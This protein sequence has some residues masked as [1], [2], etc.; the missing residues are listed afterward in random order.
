MLALSSF[1]ST[2]FGI[3]KLITY[4]MFT[5]WHFERP[6]SLYYQEASYDTSWCKNGI[7]YFCYNNQTAVTTTITTLTKQLAVSLLEIRNNKERRNQLYFNKVNRGNPLTQDK[8]GRM[9]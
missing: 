3:M 8:H 1:L 9:R 2:V 7:P 6:L 4:N 5:G